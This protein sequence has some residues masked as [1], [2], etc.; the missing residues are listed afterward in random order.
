LFSISPNI[1]ANHTGLLILCLVRSGLLEA[2]VE[3]ILTSDTF[4]SVRAT[5]LLGELLCL[6]DHFLPTDCFDPS[7]SIPSLVEQAMGFPVNQMPPTT[8]SSFASSSLSPQM[9]QQRAMEAISVL[10]LLHDVKAKTP[11]PSSMFLQM[12]MSFADF[13]RKSNQVFQDRLGELQ[14][15]RVCLLFFFML[16]AYFVEIWRISLSDIPLLQF[17]CYGEKLIRILQSY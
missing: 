8:S 11:V 3:V 12:Q 7:Q 14:L 2:L 10:S 17:R 13:S 1:T 6:S 15:N 9:K 16:Y 5:V 4:L